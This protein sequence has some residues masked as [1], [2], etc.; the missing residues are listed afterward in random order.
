VQ[1]RQNDIRRP[2][3]QKYLLEGICKVVFEKV[4]DSSSRTLICTLKPELLPPKYTET[5]EK[6]LAP[7][8]DEDLL[9]VWDINEGKWKSFRISKIQAFSTTEE[10]ERKKP[11]KTTAKNTTNKNRETV[12]EGWKRQQEKLDQA[13]SI[14]DRL[15]T[16]AEQRRRLQ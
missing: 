6:I 13:R 16:E 12:L 1:I 11:K 14:I 9:P 4:K 8:V 7:A 2:I 10:L 3:L 5:I 15:R